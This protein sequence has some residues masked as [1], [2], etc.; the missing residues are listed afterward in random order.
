MT[1]NDQQ[2]SSGTYVLT[3]EDVKNDPKLVAFEEKYPSDTFTEVKL[4]AKIPSK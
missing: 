1:Y 4:S 3:R 2:L